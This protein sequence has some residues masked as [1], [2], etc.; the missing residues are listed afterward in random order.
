MS[1]PEF[2]KELRRDQGMVVG[3]LDARF[4][5]PSGDLLGQY[6]S[7]DPQS[8]AISSAYAAA[9]NTYLRTELGYDG[10]RE[11]VP[12]GNVQPWNWERRGQGGFFGAGSPN[13]AVD[14]ARALE[15][16]PKLQVLLVTG[17]Y[18]LATPYYAAAWTMDHLGVPADLR[19][20]IARADFEAGHMMYV[21]EDVLPKWR[22]TMV[23]FI[24]R[25]SGGK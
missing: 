18:D 24:Q 16:N 12:S 2:E 3:R 6:P 19:D 22:Q 23:D 9:W 20:N 5:G 25:T 4:Q 8:S 7:Q 10:T 1:A 21:R 17:L 13:V 14:L 11:Y 15:N